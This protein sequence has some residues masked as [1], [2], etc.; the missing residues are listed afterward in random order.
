[1]VSADERDEG[2]KPD[3]RREEDRTTKIVRILH[4]VAEVVPA[5]AKAVYEVLHLFVK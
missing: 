2:S 5:V 3:S 4:A 1:M